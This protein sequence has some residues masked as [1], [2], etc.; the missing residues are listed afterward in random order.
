[1]RKGSFF[2]I[3][4][5]F[6]RASRSGSP[7]TLWLIFTLWS[8]ILTY[9]LPLHLTT[10]LPLGDETAATVPLFNLWT[11]QWNI[12]Q[13]LTPSQGGYWDAPIF[14]PEHGT[15]AFSEPQPL[16]AW[17]ALPL[18]GFSPILA[19][20]FV[21]LL[22]LTLNGWFTYWL[23]RQWHVSPQASLGA[24]LLM[25]ALPA[26]TQ[27]LGVLQ[28]TA[29]FGYLWTLLFLSRWQLH[30]ILNKAQRSTHTGINEESLKSLPTKAVF[31]PEN[32]TFRAWFEGLFASLRVIWRIN[33][34]MLKSSFA[35]AL[36]PAVTFL[37][38][39]YYGLFSLLFL[40]LYF[41]LYQ[42]SLLESNGFSRLGQQLKRLHT[43]FL[44]HVL[45]VI[46]LTVALTA[47]FPVMQQQQL[48][49]HAFQRS[50]TTIEQNSARLGD[51]FGVLDYNML[52]GQLLALHLAA[53][54]RLFPGFGLI[55]LAIF[56]S[57][58][59]PHRVK[60]YLLMAI[61]LAWLLSFGLRLH[62]AGYQPYQWLRDF[63]PGFAQ[64]RSPFRFAIFMQLHLVLLAG[65]G[66]GAIL[67]LL[68]C[69]PLGLPHN[70][71]ANLKVC[72][73][74]YICLALVLT[75]NL[76]L[77]LPLQFMPPPEPVAAWETWLKAEPQP[78]TIVILPFAADNS[79]AAFEPTVRWML[80][81]PMFQAQLINGYSG[82]FPPDHAALRDEMI[83]FPTT[84]GIAMLR[85]K[86]VVYVVVDYRLPNAP[87]KV[88]LPRVFW[89]EAARVGIYRL[90]EGIN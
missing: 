62:V 26:L 42:L 52:Y 20:N 75:E 60:F 30:V 9:P 70:R 59:K 32:Y 61:G 19:Y 7:L 16:T 73:P 27:E 1:M 3:C 65:L 17:L 33:K 68:E 66:L 6:S 64:L 51:Y 44:Y 21:L 84:K 40:P 11:L 74:F 2:R 15:F 49:R 85:A 25:P 39:G 53:G 55:L 83:Q 80:R 22:F 67:Q 28:L 89:D 18:W 37:T 10:H 71:Q 57:I 86:G 8:L 41:I 14:A 24:G 58:A 81:Q 23:L 79:V 34:Y 13:L 12:Q 43:Y 4:S 50:A 88:I 82:F 36:G 54:Q 47:P 56:G 90:G 48:A 5:Y 45:V 72:I 31:G 78:V 87:Q 35:L 29:L 38:C 69:K 46:L 63:I 76:A 77:P